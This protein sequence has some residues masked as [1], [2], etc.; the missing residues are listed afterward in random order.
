M[1]VKAMEIE[2]WHVAE[3][4]MSSKVHYAN[5]YVD[6]KVSAIFTGPESRSIYREAFWDGGNTWKIRFAPTV[7]GRWTWKTTSSNTGD[8]GLHGQTGELLCIGYKGDNPVY[9]HGFLRI[10]ENRRYFC[11]ADG[12]PFFWLGDTHWQ[13]PDTE[14]VGEC[15]HPEHGGAAC[16]A[17]GQFQH[18]LADRK[19]RG[20]TVYQTYPSAASAHWWMTKCS[21]ISPDRFRAVFDVQMNHLAR[22]GFVIALGCGHFN[23]STVIPEADLCRWARYLVARYGAHPVVWIT[24]QEMNAP[25]EM[26]GKESNRMSAWQSVARAIAG[27]DGYGHP[28]SAHQWVLDVATRPLCHEPWHDWFALQGGHR[29]SGLTPQVRYKGYYDSAPTRPILET[30]AMYERVDCGGVNTSDEA[31]QSAWKALLCGSPGYTYGAAGIWA[32]KWDANDP[33][34]KDYNHAVGSWHEGMSFPGAAQMI[35]LKQFFSAMNWTELTPRFQ[36][37]AWSEWSDGE[38]S[39]LATIGNQLYVAYCYGATSEGTLKQLEVS[40]AYVARWFDPRKGDYVGSPADIRSPTGA[41]DVP[42]KPSA[43]DW[44][45]RVEKRLDTEQEKRGGAGIQSNRI[46][47]IQ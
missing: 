19:S 33:R 30:E 22:Q 38:R 6:V 1:F 27:C 12:T 4:T 31:R 18:L 29:N 16:P 46:S 45:L 28:H 41:W 15:N 47:N 7:S 32:L 39:V 23:N 44:V 21:R 14:R 17:G 2:C 43:E 20:F 25:D 42:E 37:P 9:R 10:S 8:A 40:G 13:M 5:P 11:H 36:D 3:I 24:C 26:G 35:M 34:W